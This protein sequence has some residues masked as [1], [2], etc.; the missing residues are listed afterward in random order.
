MWTSNEV[1]FD[2]ENCVEWLESLR[3]SA[4]VIFQLCLFFC[5]F[6][7]CVKHFPSSIQFHPL[8]SLCISNVWS[9]LKMYLF[10]IWILFI[11]KSVLLILI[12]DKYLYF[13][14]HF[15]HRLWKI[16]KNFRHV[17]ICLYVCISFSNDIRQLWMTQLAR[18]HCTHYIFSYSVNSIFSEFIDFVFLPVVNCLL[19]LSLGHDL[20]Q[21]WG[22]T[23]P[24]R[25]GLLWRWLLERD[26]SSVLP[27]R[28]L[29]REDGHEE[30][31][32]SLGEMCVG[33]GR[34]EMR[35][36]QQE[37]LGDDGDQPFS[38]IVRDPGSL[39]GSITCWRTSTE[40]TITTGAKG[41]GGVTV[42]LN[43]HHCYTTSAVGM[44]L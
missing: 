24:R 19:T 16:K 35:R 31:K 41:A 42:G 17:C 20:L 44:I 10:I 11:Y 43:H 25:G 15:L 9:H 26:E 7:V 12:Y 18:T 38:L 28:E 39:W 8:F 37:P 33:V 23:T 29:N 32:Q 34:R 5:S 30:E 40:G 27:G 3:C 14:F 4:S 21:P 36:E 1:F 2:G 6:Y 22:L 13:H